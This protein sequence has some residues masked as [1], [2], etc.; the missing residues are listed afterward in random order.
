MPNS[1]DSIY[2]RPC[3]SLSYDDLMPEGNGACSNAASACLLRDRV[4]YTNVGYRMGGWTDGNTT[5]SILYMGDLCPIGLMYEMTVEMTCGPDF[6]TPVF[7]SEVECSY[8]VTWQTWGACPPTAFPKTP[9]PPQEVTRPI[10]TNKDV[11][12][13]RAEYIFWLADSPPGTYFVDIL[14]RDSE[15]VVDM[16]RNM[17]CA[18]RTE[19][20]F[21]LCSGEFMGGDGN[22]AL[23]IDD[24][25]AMQVFATLGGT[26]EVFVT[27]DTK[28]LPT[29]NALLPNLPSA[30]HS[31][32]TIVRAQTVKTDPVGP[33]RMFVEHAQ[34]HSV[35]YVATNSSTQPTHAFL[36]IKDYVLQVGPDPLPT[37]V[38][39]EVPD[40]GLTQG[41]KAGIV[42][43]MVAVVAGGI[44]VGVVLLVQRYRRK[45]Y[46]QLDGG[47]NATIQNDQGDSS[48]DL[49]ESTPVRTSQGEGYR[50][51]T[52]SVPA[53]A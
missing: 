9:F 48:G 27:G 6:G 39:P 17:E 24:V 20:D 4:P 10:D 12:I 40:D 21:F 32:S 5:T 43:A 3:N 36:E 42:I 8:Y 30:A 47:E 53:D 33:I 31:I 14:T 28:F 46:K 16:H 34:E 23:S 22:I 51:T 26:M 49:D 41:A 1:D 7:V 11:L 19:D 13:R 35:L 44:A 2:F 25:A 18:P 37:S 38:E 45:V 15:T 52:S 29:S 50:A